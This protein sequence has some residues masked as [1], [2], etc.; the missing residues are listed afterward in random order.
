LT[1]VQFIR[2]ILLILCGP[3]AETIFEMNDLLVVI[4]LSKDGVLNLENA[5]LNFFY[6]TPVLENDSRIKAYTFLHE[7]LAQA[8]LQLQATMPVPLTLTGSGSIS[9]FGKDLVIYYS[10]VETVGSGFM[11]IAQSTFFLTSLRNAGIQID[12]YMDRVRA[13]GPNVDIPPALLLQNLVVHIADIRDYQPPVG[14][15]IINRFNTR[16]DHHSEKSMP[17]HSNALTRRPPDTLTRRSSDT[18]DTGRPFRTGA[19][20][21]CPCC[22]RWGHVRE[23]CMQ[24]CTTYLC[25]QYINANNEFCAAQAIKWST[26]Q[27]QQKTHQNSVIHTLRINQPEFY[28]QHTDDDIRDSLDFSQDSDFV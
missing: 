13:V 8:M 14:H 16:S 4:K 18:P 28:A 25:M 23:N 9:S 20:T 17:M 27:T 3:N 24:L 2:S 6:T 12:T 7:L 1:Y 19:A 5:T 22:G 10:V 21:R 26:S 11:P 15:H